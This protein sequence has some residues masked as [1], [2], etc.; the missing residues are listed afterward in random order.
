VKDLLLAEVEG[1]DSTFCPSGQIALCSF[2]KQASPS[3]SGIH[4]LKRHS[5]QMV[6]ELK[7][8][9]DKT[10]ASSF[11]LRWWLSFHF[12]CFRLR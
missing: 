1:F 6:Q 12:P 7:D 9:K 8:P 3:L 11:L 4:G 10:D 5:M 2:Q